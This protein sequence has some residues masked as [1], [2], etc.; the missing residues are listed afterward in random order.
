MRNYQEIIKTFIN[1]TGIKPHMH[2]RGCFESWKRSQAKQEY[3]AGMSLDGLEAIRHWNDSLIREFAASSQAER[4]NRGV[5]VQFYG[6]VHM[7]SHQE[8]DRKQAAVLTSHALVLARNESIACSNKPTLFFVVNSGF[9]SISTV[10]RGCLQAAFG[11]APSDAISLNQQLR[12]ECS[13]RISKYVF[14]LCSTDLLL[15]KLF[16]GSDQHVIRILNLKS[17]QT[18]KKNIQLNKDGGIHQTEIFIFTFHSMCC[19]CQF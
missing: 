3:D 2:G 9:N 6:L 17:K 4:G 8:N 19:K 15:T 14:Y 16:Q 7:W 10:Q 12:E 1:K 5:V 18:N 11:W 13:Q